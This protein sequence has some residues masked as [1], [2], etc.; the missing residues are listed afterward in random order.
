MIC[1]IVFFSFNRE[2]TSHKN[3]VLQAVRNV[4]GFDLHPVQIQGGMALLKSNIIEMETGEG[5][6]VTAVLP[7]SILARDGKGLLLATANDYL[8][9]R[10]ADWMRP[11]YQQLHLSVGCVQAG[12]SR[13]DRKT[14]YDCDITYGTIREFSF[15]H[16][17]DRLAERQVLSAALSHNPDQFVK[18]VQREPYAIIVDEAD[19]ILIDEARQPL[20]ISGPG[21]NVPNV[22]HAAC[23]GWAAKIAVQ[24]VEFQHFMRLSGSRAIALT[25]AGCSHI[26]CMSMPTEMSPL[27]LTEIL[28]KV[29]TA[30]YAHYTIY[31]DHHY[32]VD[33]DEIVIVD[34]FTGRK[35][36]GRAWEGGIHQAIEARENVTL[37]PET[38]PI[39]NITVKEYINRFPK[40]SG[41]TGTAKESR[42]EFKSVY[43]TGVIQI[44]PHQPSQRKTVPTVVCYTMEEKWNA[45]IQQILQCQKTEQPVLIG[46]RTIEHSEQLSICLNAA[47]IEHQILNA[48]NHQQEAEI[49][50]TAGEPKRVTV[51]TN[52]AG[53]GTDI[54][55]GYAAK[56]AG[57]LYVIGTELHASSRIDRQ[58]AGRCGRQGDPGS[59]C[60]YISLE[61]EILTTAYGAEIAEE[62][63]TSLRKQQNLNAIQQA[64]YAAQK[65][66]ENQ[67][68]KDRLALSQS[69]QELHDSYHQLGLDPV[70]DAIPGR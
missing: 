22:A 13:V 39:A 57:G 59:F 10:D 14:Q 54:Q 34:E 23:Y 36:P 38:A 30:L 26:S 51:A 17:H 40:L 42:H 20:L 27:T 33:G 25:N 68:Y 5:K 24:L 19:S 46:T 18:Q 44:P 15:D 6:T 53:R 4:L 12:M 49:I 9:Q 63:R 58:L 69:S 61:D 43:G 56:A 21:S 35:S 3:D 52:M 67:Q 8:A 41:M 29:E 16:L 60:Q 64:L 66:I 62:K 11:V 48:H 70:L 32:V 31:R 55:L 50:S 28:H 47:N 7:L 1:S 65:H 45:I 2:I 37:T